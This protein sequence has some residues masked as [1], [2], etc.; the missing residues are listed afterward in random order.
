MSSREL[1]KLPSYFDATEHPR[2]S[3]IRQIKKA[4]HHKTV[5]SENLIENR[6]SVTHESVLLITMG[7]DMYPR[8]WRKSRRTSSALRLPAT[9]ANSSR[10]RITHGHPL[11]WRRCCHTVQVGWKGGWIA[12]NVSKY[13]LMNDRL[14]SYTNLY[15]AFPVN[16]SAGDT[17]TPDP[18]TVEMQ[19]NSNVTVFQS[20]Y[21]YTAAA[22]LA[23][24]IGFVVVIPTFGGFWKMGHRTSLNPLEV[25]KAF[26]ASLLQEHSS[27]VPAHHLTTA[28]RS[29]KGKYG[30]IIE[31]YQTIG[32]NGLGVRLR[33]SRLGIAEP[34]RV[35]TPEFRVLYN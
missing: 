3:T 18:Q 12:L 4:H 8:R 33:A 24:M 35:R 17:R 5:S 14:D 1:P 6:Q 32:G 25:A 34:S 16:V 2:K 19:Q 10:S 26:D 13:A 31:E 9:N 28:V 21:P 7:T 30:E 20:N 15:E 27:N 22:L 29:K 11:C 23:M